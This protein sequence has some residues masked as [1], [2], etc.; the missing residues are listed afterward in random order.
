MMIRNLLLKPWKTDGTIQAHGLFRCLMVISGMR[1]G[2]EV[3]QVGGE[4]GLLVKV[5]NVMG[6]AS[7]AES[8]VCCRSIL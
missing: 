7:P 4:H 5:E 2:H 3:C 6:K 8:H 1:A